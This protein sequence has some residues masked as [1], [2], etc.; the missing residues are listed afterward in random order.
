LV[1]FIGSTGSSEGFATIH[2]FNTIEW[3]LVES[4]TG[5]DREYMTELEFPLEVINYI[6][7]SGD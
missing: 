6:E 5:F 1:T 2:K 4:G 7:S 3:E